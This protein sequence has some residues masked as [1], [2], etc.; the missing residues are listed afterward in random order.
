LDAHVAPWTSE[1]FSAVEQRHVTQATSASEALDNPDSIGQSGLGWLLVLADA[2]AAILL[3]ADLIVVSL[4]VF[5]RYVL[6]V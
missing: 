5:Y 4:S 2:V 6:A 1:R 3:A